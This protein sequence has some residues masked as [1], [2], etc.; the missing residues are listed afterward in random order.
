MQAR[1]GLEQSNSTSRTQKRSAAGKCTRCAHL[2]DK[3]GQQAQRVCKGAQQAQQAK[4]ER[5]AGGAHS[6]RPHSRLR[7]SQ[8]A[9]AAPPG[10]S[11]QQLF[12]QAR[13]PQLG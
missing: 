1:A 8:E 4:H 12:H 6:G 9:A 13:S 10:P 5:L 11:T 2:E 3:I 7:W